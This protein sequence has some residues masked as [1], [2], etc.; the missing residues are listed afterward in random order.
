[1]KPIKK[2]DGF[3]LVEILVTVLV[4]SIGL[5]GLAGLQVKSMKSNHS[6]YL[7]TQAT[8]MAYDMID[9][10][11]ANPNA[12][13]TGVT[14]YVAQ[15]TYT[16]DTSTDPYTVSSPTATANCSNTTGCT[17]TQMANT[18]VNQWR[19]DLATQLPGGVGVICLDDTTDPEADAGDLSDDKCSNSGNIYAI[20]I[21]WVDDRDS[22]ASNFKR[23]VT[24]Y[25]P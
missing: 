8:I 17:T 18:D 7:R 13:T 21:W 24:S 25:V 19:V 3:T 15:G 14:D 22:A 4:L 20:K 2:H 5:L 9:R 12:V 11:R 23:F 6:S 16:I 1:M 10:M